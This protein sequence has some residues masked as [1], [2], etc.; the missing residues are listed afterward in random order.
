MGDHLK[1][2]PEDEEHEEEVEDASEEATRTTMPAVTLRNEI[3]GQIRPIGMAR[4]DPHQ[5]ALG[6]ARIVDC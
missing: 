5:E 3:G 2:Q 1:D 4:Q 6:P